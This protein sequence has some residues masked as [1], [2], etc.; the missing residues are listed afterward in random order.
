MF[1]APEDQDQVITLRKDIS[2]LQQTNTQL[3][4][5]VKRYTHI[6]KSLKRHQQS[7]VSAGSLGRNPFADGASH[8]LKYS[9]RYSYSY[10]V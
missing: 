1:S 5:T 4:A 9:C 6:L 7:F 10:T 8:K 2:D 3:D